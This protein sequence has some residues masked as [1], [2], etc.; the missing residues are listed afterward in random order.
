MKKY[1][2]GDEFFPYSKFTPPIK[3]PEMAGRIGAMMRPPSRLWSDPEL[4][5]RRERIPSFDGEE[6]ELLIMEPRHVSTDCCLVY[7]HGGGFFFGAAVSHYQNAKAY[8]LRTPCRVVFVQY[9]LAPAHPY[10]VPTE[11]CYAA[12]CHAHIRAD[13]LGINRARLAVGGDSAGGCL[14]AAVAQMARDRACDIK[15]CFQLLIYPFTD[16]SMDSESNRLFSDTPMWNSK[17]SKIMLGGYLRDPE[18]GRMAH[19][20][21]LAGSCENLPPAYIETAEFDCLRDDGLRYGEKLREAGTEVVLNETKGTMHGFDI[22]GKAPTTI[23]AVAARI[24]Y[25][26]RGFSL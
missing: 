10:P 14:A 6:I 12:L 20:S 13:E 25:M 7:Y 11:D 23:A 2:I 1:N 26:R 21:P 16:C 19:A 3:S 4:A 17:L 18:A 22:A 8:A 15:L 24:D 9:R 5:V